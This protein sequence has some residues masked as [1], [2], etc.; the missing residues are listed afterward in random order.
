MSNIPIGSDTKDAPWNESEEYCKD[1]GSDKLEIDD[2][3]SFK[4]KQWVNYV[5]TECGSKIINEPDYE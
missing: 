3:G 5:C 4:G 1:C 2:M